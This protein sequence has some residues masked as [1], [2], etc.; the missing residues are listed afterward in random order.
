[1]KQS[2][3]LLEM[4]AKSEPMRALDDM[5]LTLL[6]LNGGRGCENEYAILSEF[7]FNH[8]PQLNDNGRIRCRRYLMDDNGRV[9]HK[10]VNETTMQE[11]NKQL[12]E[13][14]NDMYH[15][16]SSDFK[17]RYRE[18]YFEI[19]EYLTWSADKSWFSDANQ[20]VIP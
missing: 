10:H 6:H 13:L 15:S 14:L 5:Y 17:Q 9:V 20:G 8:S 19:L 2:P 16:Q 4:E 18:N 3:D 1:M 7:I 11:R 12:I